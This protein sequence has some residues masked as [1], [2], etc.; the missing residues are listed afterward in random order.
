M[1]IWLGYQYFLGL[2]VEQ[3]IEKGIF[4][5]EESAK[6]GN[7]YAEEELIMI[8]G[9]LLDHAFGSSDDLLNRI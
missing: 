2:G 7:S 5:A 6:N 1:R 8:Y 3:N 9:D 4:W